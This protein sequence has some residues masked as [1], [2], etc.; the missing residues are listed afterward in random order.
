MTGEKAT[1]NKCKILGYISPKLICD[2]YKTEI[3]HLLN[4]N[5]L[6]DQTRRGYERRLKWCSHHNVMQ[7]YDKLFDDVVEEI[8]RRKDLCNA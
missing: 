7:E 4:S 6:D 1:P 3:E 2:K 5:W 8:T